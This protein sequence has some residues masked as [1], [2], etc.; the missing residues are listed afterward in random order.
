MLPH[1]LHPRSG[2]ELFTPKKRSPPVWR[3]RLIVLWLTL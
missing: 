1:L 3:K 2:L